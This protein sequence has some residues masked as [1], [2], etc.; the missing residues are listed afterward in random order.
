MGGAPE[1]PIQALFVM[2]GSDPCRLASRARPMHVVDSR[3]V[4][5]RS[6]YG[7]RPDLASHPR[8]ATTETAAT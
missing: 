1:S 8:S 7:V 5:G 2:P 4:Q 6:A 3:K